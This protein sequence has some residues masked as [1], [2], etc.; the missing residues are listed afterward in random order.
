MKRIILFLLGYLIS[1]MSYAQDPV[2]SQFTLNQLYYNPA[3]T[4]YA[5]DTRVFATH[6]RQWGGLGTPFN[7]S[8]VS[9]DTYL[10]NC[11]RYERKNLSMGVGA[12]VF[13][14]QRGM[15]L[16]T[17]TFALSAAGHAYLNEQLRLSAGIQG[18]VVSEKF[19]PTNLTFVSQYMGTA[20]PLAQGQL[21]SFK[22]DWSA[23]ALIEYGE[24]EEDAPLVGIGASVRHLG[25]KANL[26]DNYLQ[27]LNV[28][29]YYKI[30][31]NM[32][33]WS[34]GLGHEDLSY[35]AFVPALQV[36][37]QGGTMQWEAGFNF[38]YSPV[39]LGVW[40]R[41]LPAPQRRDA[42]VASLG[43]QVGNVLFQYSHD[44]TLF[45][46]LNGYTRG[47]HEIGIRVLMDSY[48]CLT[49]GRESAS[50]RGMR[51]RY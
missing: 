24:E 23:G 2:F 40:V 12:Q 1:V 46:S 19:D 30:P 16:S 3:F 13:T 26:R 4:G 47:A 32:V 11:K 48:I 10:A 31:L 9:V 35:R 8:F 39:W 34:R 38:I 49:G 21:S 51:C 45:S 29:A 6:R 42:L 25:G 15:A 28:Q 37:R 43:W 50:R 33:L 7:T 41:G 36:T 27:S 44:M 22:A 20:D 5:E 17:T 14:D 18:G